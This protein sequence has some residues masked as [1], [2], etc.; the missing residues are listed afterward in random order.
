MWAAAVARTAPVT[1]R[2]SATHPL[3]AACFRPTSRPA[4]IRVAAPRPSAPAGHWQHLPRHRV[5]TC[6]YSP[7]IPTPPH[8]SHTTHPAAPPQQRTAHL[9][10]PGFGAG[11]QVVLPPGAARGCAGGGPCSADT[12]QTAWHRS[13]PQERQRGEPPGARGRGVHKT[14]Q[15]LWRARGP[16]PGS[17][18]IHRWVERLLP[19]SP[20]T[21]RAG[22]F[23]CRYCSVAL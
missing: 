7:R 4:R 13:W 10:E 5:A 20:A 2:G 8:P 22:R 14:K 11:W 21:A 18:R 3:H 15:G 1:A 23:R 9:M 17:A 6:T 12:T 16:G 19:R